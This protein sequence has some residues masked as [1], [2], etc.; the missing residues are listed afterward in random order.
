MESRAFWVVEL[1]KNT[2]IPILQR[3]DRRPSPQCWT[4]CYVFL[5][6]RQPPHATSTPI[7][8]PQQRMRQIQMPSSSVITF[9]HRKYHCLNSSGFQTSSIDIRK[10]RSDIWH[11]NNKTKFKMS[12]GHSF[13]FFFSF[14]RHLFCFVFLNNTRLR[15]GPSLVLSVLEKQSQNGG[16]KQRQAALLRLTYIELNAKVLARNRCLLKRK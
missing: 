1:C 16:F 12:T 15:T 8:L 5:F 10:Q 4:S 11:E 2:I 9:R 3:V 6:S 14:P 7:V 13:Y